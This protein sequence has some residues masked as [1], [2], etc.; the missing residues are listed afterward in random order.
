MQGRGGVRREVCITEESP[1]PHSKALDPQARVMCP[2]LCVG[3]VHSW[4]DF[5]SGPVVK[6]LPSNAGDAGLI[7]GQGTKIPRAA[8]QLSLRATT[9][10]PGHLN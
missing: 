5:T 4:G 9:T 7:P 8:G 2:H 10:E 1:G 3:S 6:N